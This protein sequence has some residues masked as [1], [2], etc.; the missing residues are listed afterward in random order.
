MKRAF[1]SL[2]FFLMALMLYSSV[3]AH[4]DENIGGDVYVGG[5]SPTLSV[6]LPRDA[7]AAG[8]SVSAN[9]DVAGD[10]HL[11]G[12]DVDA[13]GTVGGD[14]YAAGASVSVKGPVRDDASVSGF[15][16]RF[17]NGASVGGNAR[18]AAGSMILD[19]PFGGSLAAA[20]GKIELNS[21]ISGDARLIAADIEFGSDAR[22]GGILT[23]SAP[24]EIDIPASVVPAERVRYKPIDTGLIG[25]GFEGKIPSFWPSFFGIVGA[26]ILAL[27]FLM[28]VAAV[29]LAFL[30]ETVDRLRGR[31]IQ[32]PGT[33]LLSGFLGLSMLIG[34]VPVSGMTLVGI[35]FIPIVLL[36]LFAAW[37]LGYLL[38]VYAVSYR[39]YE[40]FRTE[41][42]SLGMKLLTVAAGLIV[43]AVLNFIPFAGWLINLAVVLLGLGSMTLF[44][45]D[46]LSGYATGTGSTATQAD[47]ANRK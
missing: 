10:V 5:T 13:A 22:I 24:E 18:I 7:F 1:L 17:E 4:G 36:I 38:G 3:I 29:F 47:A 44:I 34:L 37:T 20:A 42:D 8:F 30:P 28:A 23:Y 11:S 26:F 9:S 27:A 21:Q 45:A 6:D 40:A 25:E 31:V 41:P 16:V 32:K 33:A 46:R 14:L 19:A 35:P 39:V 15:S 43:F 2:P 12:F